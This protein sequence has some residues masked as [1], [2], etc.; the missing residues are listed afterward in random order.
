LF[1]LINKTKREIIFFENINFVPR[2]R[3]SFALGF[4]IVIKRLSV[5]L[6]PLSFEFI[7][8]SFI[9]I[10]TVG[11]GKPF[12]IVIGEYGRRQLLDQLGFLIRDFDGKFPI[13]IG[14]DFVA[15]NDE[16]D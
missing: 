9:P 5:R 2:L 6:D 13:F 15:V 8:V 16:D 1:R 14:A 3:N 12:P 11:S 4:F 7:D 10:C